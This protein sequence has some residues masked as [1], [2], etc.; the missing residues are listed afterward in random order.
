MSEI[1]SGVIYDREHRPLIP[2]RGAQLYSQMTHTSVLW[3]RGVG[4]QNSDNLTMLR[5]ASGQLKQL[6]G[7]GSY[8][9]AGGVAQTLCGD[10]WKVLG[11][12]RGCVCT[13]QDSTR[14]SKDWWHAQSSMGR[15]LLK[16]QAFNQD[17]KKSLG[18]KDPALER[19]SQVTRCCCSIAKSCLTLCDLMDYSTP[20]SSVLHDP[21]QFAQIY[22]HRVS[23]AIQPSHAPLPPLL[24]PPIFPSI[25]V[26]SD[27]LVLHIRWPN[28]GASAQQQSFQW[29]FR[30]DFL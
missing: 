8:S 29:I 28:I 5:I 20:G 16:P 10:T 9:Y 14:L 22:I 12:G 25:K 1:S 26:F 23:D 27:E 11:G 19:S 17:P 6:E 21:L 3:C 7:V 13:E 24:L 18:N 4:S 15:N 2:E 30:A